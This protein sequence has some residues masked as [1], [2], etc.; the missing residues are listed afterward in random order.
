MRPRD[1]A[2]ANDKRELLFSAA[3]WTCIVCGRHLRE[4]IGQLAHRIIASKHNLK[5][6]GPATIHHS[7]NLVPVCSLACN[8]ACI[9]NFLPA[10]DL[11]IKIQLSAAGMD[12]GE[13]LVDHY[14][15]LREEFRQ[16]REE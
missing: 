3:N 12:T 13:F 5:L 14:R 7:W 1:K 16:R 15:E 2:E 10:R 6:H 9:V 11:L 4:G 8:S